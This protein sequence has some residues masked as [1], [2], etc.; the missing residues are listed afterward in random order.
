MA[1]ADQIIDFPT[2]PDQF[3]TNGLALTAT[4]LS[5]QAVDFALESGP[6]LFSPPDHWHFSTTGRV[7]VVA[8]QPG[9]DNWN[10]APN[11]TNVFEVWG[12]YTLQVDDARGLAEPVLGLHT[13]LLN[14]VLTNSTS[15]F[16]AAGGTQWVCTGWTLIGHDPATGATNWFVMTVTNNATLTWH[17][18]TNYWLQTVAAP[19]GFIEPGDSWC[20]ANESTIITATPHSYYHFDHWTNSASG[21]N[22]PFALIMDIPKSARAV[23]A[24]NLASHDTPEWWLAEHGWTNDFDAA[25][26]ADHEPDGVPTWQEYVADTDPR[27]SNSY[28]RITSIQAEGSNA[29]V[30][31]WR[32]S[33]SRVYQIH[34]RPLGTA[35]GPWFTQQLFRGTDT[36]IDDTHSPPPPRQMYSVAP[37]RP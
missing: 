15:L 29:P 26:L 8:R 10:P 27:D 9:D 19:H 35:E 6:A 5:G 1:K 11:V 28:L 22:N 33:T 13:H 20:P 37:L 3:I 36:W 4:A 14:T 34:H 21:T 12:L 24:E 23:F 18:T 32:A 7:T 30:I 25:A 17:W 16:L 2:I 31:Q